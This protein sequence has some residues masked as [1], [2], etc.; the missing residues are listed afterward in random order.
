MQQFKFNCIK[1]YIQQVFDLAI[2]NR[3]FTRVH[4]NKHYDS[5]YFFFPVRLMSMVRTFTMCMPILKLMLFVKL[6]KFY[7][8]YVSFWYFYFNFMLYINYCNHYTNWSSIVKIS[9][10]YCQ[11]DGKHKSYY[12]NLGF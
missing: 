6:H 8:W 11:V 12:Y 3:I 7:S 2:K 1:K 10:A 4:G 9:I 5:Y